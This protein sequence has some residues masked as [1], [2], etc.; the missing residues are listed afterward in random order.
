MSQLYVYPGTDVLDY[1]DVRDDPSVPY[2]T[3]SNGERDYDRV[4][5][6]SKRL[7][8]AVTAVHGDKRCVQQSY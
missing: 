5:Q 2:S 8:H 3:G 6:Y 1:G 7:S 4:Q